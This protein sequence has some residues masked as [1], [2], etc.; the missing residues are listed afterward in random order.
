MDKKWIY[1]G[2]FIPPFAKFENLRALSDNGVKIPEGWKLVNHHMTIAFNDGSERAQKL[3]DFYK[4]VFG[5]QTNITIDGIGV[6]DDAIAVRV[7]F[8]N[9]IANKIPHI[10][11]AIPQNG[12]PVNSNKITNWVD[13]EPYEISGVVTHF[14][15][16]K[17]N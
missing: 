9:P 14:L 15:A 12:K 13:I 2:V 17:N 6:S 7:R 1:F 16:G 4:K 10:T 11:I 3:Y 5:K 8:G